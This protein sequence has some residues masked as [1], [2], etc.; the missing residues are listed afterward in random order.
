MVLGRVVGT[1]VCTTKDENLQGVKLLV[2][3]HCDPRLAPQKAWTIAADAVGAGEGEVV[4]VVTGSSAR[5][6]T[7]LKNLP[8]DATIVAIVDRVDLMAGA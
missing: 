6:T 1:V 2:V 8:L 5:L 4:L 3:Q 7:R